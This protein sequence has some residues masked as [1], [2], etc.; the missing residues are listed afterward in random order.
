MYNPFRAE[1]PASVALPA[2][3]MDVLVPQHL[4]TATFA[5]G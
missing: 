4:E 5:V 3:P 2:P 1:T